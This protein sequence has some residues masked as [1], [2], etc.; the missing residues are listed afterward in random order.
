VGNVENAGRVADR[1]VLLGDAGVLDGHFPTAKFDQL[2]PDF[3]VS[4][5]KRGSFKH[6]S[7][8]D[9]KRTIKNDKISGAQKGGKR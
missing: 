7:I 3:L 9:E 6:S 4:G 5:T 1:M 2:S 8:K